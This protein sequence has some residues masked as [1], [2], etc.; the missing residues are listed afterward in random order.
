M[1]LVVPYG[2]GTGRGNREIH[3]LRGSNMFAI[4]N[5]YNLYCCIHKIHFVMLYTVYNRITMRSEITF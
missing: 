1:L 3:F 5:N 2:V 4:L